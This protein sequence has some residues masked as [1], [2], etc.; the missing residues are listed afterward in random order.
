MILEGVKK[1]VGKKD[2]EYKGKEMGF[3]TFSI[4]TTDKTK[5]V[6]KMFREEFIEPNVLEKLDLEKLVGH[7]VNVVTEEDFMSKR[8]RIV[9]IT[10]K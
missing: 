5:C 9:N 7:E 6:G 2:G 1:I 3:A 4:P 10:V 8:S